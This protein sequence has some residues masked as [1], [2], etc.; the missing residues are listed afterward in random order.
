MESNIWEIEDFALDDM[1]EDEFAG[2]TES[3][4]RFSVEVMPRATPLT[5]ELLRIYL[6][7][8]DTIRRVHL[9]RDPKGDVLGYSTTSRDAGETNVHILRAI[10]SVAPPYRRQGIGTQLIRHVARIAV[11]MGRVYLQGEA[12]DTVEAGIAFAESLGA[13]LEIQNHMN[14]LDVAAVDR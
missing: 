10:T 8:P 9:I 11:D 14:W 7:S 3:A 12:W 2:F 5:P 4:N 13:S 6:G 1:T